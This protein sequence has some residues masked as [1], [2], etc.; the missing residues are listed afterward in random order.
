ARCRH[1]TTMPLRSIFGS[2]AVANCKRACDWLVAFTQ[3]RFRSAPSLVRGQ[4]PTASEL[5]IGS[6]PSR[7]K[8]LY[9][10]G[11]GKNTQIVKPFMKND[12]NE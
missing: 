8:S 1:A 7:K 10:G 4:S 3:P 9:R 6:L 5:A 11:T 12:M 2:W